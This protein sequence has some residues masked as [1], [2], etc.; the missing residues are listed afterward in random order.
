MTLDESSRN[1]AMKEILKVIWKDDQ[2][3]DSFKK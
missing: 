1:N 2:L 3:S